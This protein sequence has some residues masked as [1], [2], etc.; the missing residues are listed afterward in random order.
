MTRA[1]N[2]CS[3]TMNLIAQRMWD[4][5]GML[6]KAPWTRRWLIYS[7]TSGAALCA[8]VVWV[9]VGAG[10]P[11]DTVQTGQATAAGIAD[12][13]PESQAAPAASVN[14][15]D[16]HAAAPATHAAKQAVAKLT[17]E[18]I[19]RSSDLTFEQKRSQIYDL[20]EA[21]GQTIANIRDGTNYFRTCNRL[22]RYMVNFSPEAE[23]AFI[24]LVER[25]SWY[26]ART[27]DY[28]Q[29][30]NARLDGIRLLEPTV[31][32]GVR[33]GTIPGEIRQR[34]VELSSRGVTSGA[35][36]G[37]STDMR[38]L[39]SRIVRWSVSAR[40]LF[41]QLVAIRCCQ[42][43]IRIAHA[44]DEETAAFLKLLSDD[45]L[46]AS[47][48]KRRQ[49]MMDIEIENA[50]LEAQAYQGLADAH[51]EGTRVAKEKMGLDVRE[52]VLEAQKKARTLD[53]QRGALLPM[54][55]VVPQAELDVLLTQ[56]A[57]DAGIIEEALAELL[58]DYPWPW[59]V[60]TIKPEGKVYELTSR[61]AS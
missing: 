29:I 33:Q 50:R 26:E 2:L 55:V 36:Y 24:A 59:K 16:H 48:F 45:L 34:Y 32:E 49:S 39:Q 58:L 4:T 60:D 8:M 15:G 23:R 13:Q 18:E 42:R 52:R 5:A 30:L 20:A 57:E 41:G 17:D 38:D 1:S 56:L 9:C 14:A 21:A 7:A 25:V 44:V 27:A 10:T 54:G 46:I 37:G 3:R 11:G 31:Y 61:P 53:R 35:W 12:A 40:D 22:S 47:G 43:S 6:R 51:P 28:C 19:L